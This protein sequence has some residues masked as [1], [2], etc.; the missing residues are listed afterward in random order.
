M[1]K[2]STTSQKNIDFQWDR[3]TTLEETGGTEILSYNVQ[4]DAGS[5]GYTFLNRVGY[6]A[7][8]DENTYSISA[9]IEVGREYQV[10]IAAKNYWGWG[11]FS[12]I[13][14]IKA[15]SFPEQVG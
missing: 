12:E 11:E 15:A 8:F 4:W 3:L 1:I 9:N 10:R 14:T 2:L 6:S 5:E 7:I 13:L